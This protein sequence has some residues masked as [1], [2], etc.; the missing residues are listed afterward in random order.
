[1]AGTRVASRQAIHAAAVPWGTLRPALAVLFFAQ[2]ALG[3]LLFSLLPSYGVDRLGM[4]MAAIGPI[5][6]CFFLAEMTLKIPAGSAVDRIGQKPLMLAGLLGATLTL[7]ALPFLRHPVALA[8]VLFLHGTS[9]AP[10]WPVVLS[11][12]ADRVEEPHRGTAMGAVFTTWLSGLGLGYLT[13]V[14]LTDHPVPLRFGVLAVSWCVALLTALFTLPRRSVRLS[15]Q[16]LIPFS[17]VRTTVEIARSLIGTPRL[18]LGLFCQNWAPAMFMFVLKPYLEKERGFS[19]THISELLV[20][21]GCMA[22]VMMLPMGRLG[23]RFAKRVLVSG[24]MAFAGLL[25]GVFPYV[26][27]PACLAALVGLAG[28]A[29]ATVLPTMNAVLVLHSPPSRRALQLAAF[30]AIE[31][32][33]WALG[34]PASG[35]LWVRTGPSS[36]FFI[37]AAVL[38][39][40]A[41]VYAVSPAVFTGDQGV[42]PS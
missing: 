5:V 25:V 1:M 41:G 19:P 8:V 21:G 37:G 32:C 17:P 16:E 6:L 36:P 7:I 33:G 12:T 10:L 20:G 11:Y 2:F 24:G 39:V 27:H 15:R 30:M 26:H 35:V 14:V 22:L 13:S 42:T 23:D 40:V 28:V 4:T 3:G 18:T 29:Y 34:P 9:V 38:L 31:Q